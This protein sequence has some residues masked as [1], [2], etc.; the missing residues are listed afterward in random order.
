MHRTFRGLWVR[1]LIGG[2]GWGGRKCT[3]AILRAECSGGV[4]GSSSAPSV[5]GIPPSVGDEGVTGVTY[6][7]CKV[8]LYL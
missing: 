4:V 3:S 8:L 6:L 1:R 2:G 7:P 5:C